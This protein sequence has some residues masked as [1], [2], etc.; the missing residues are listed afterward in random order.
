MANLDHHDVGRVVLDA[1]D[2]HAPLVIEQMAETALW[3]DAISETSKYI[4][5]PMAKMYLRAYPSAGAPKTGFL[6]ASK[7][8][9]VS[10]R[11]IFDACGNFWIQVDDSSF[12]D[13]SEFKGKVCVN[14]SKGPLTSDALLGAHVCSGGDW[15]CDDQDGGKG[16]EGAIAQVWSSGY[17]SVKWDHDLGQFKYRVGANGQHDLVFTST[18]LPPPQGWL[19]M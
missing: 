4:V 9:F 14:D 7:S 11:E 1:F 17:V 8:R 10:K 2:H 13:P 5:K 16:N 6:L 15:A 12:V 19:C 18:P 3:A